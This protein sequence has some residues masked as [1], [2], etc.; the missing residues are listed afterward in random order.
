MAEGGTRG[1]SYDYY[2]HPE[3]VLTLREKETGHQE[4][5]PAMKRTC[6][7][8]KSSDIS[9]SLQVGRNQAPRDGFEIGIVSPLTAATHPRAE[10]GAR[11][12]GPASMSAG[13]PLHGRR[14]ALPMHKRPAPSG[15]QD[16]LTFKFAALISD[17]ASAPK[18]TTRL[19]P[20]RSLGIGDVF[21]QLMPALQM[22]AS[23]S[24]DPRGRA[25]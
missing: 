2:E 6:S 1:F 10:A 4:T 23:I 7:T 22:P 3:S 24:A 15:R 13:D 19:R 18:S 21:C 17:L 25:T 12:P 8:G 16:L 20:S 5:F 14:H 9:E 11:P